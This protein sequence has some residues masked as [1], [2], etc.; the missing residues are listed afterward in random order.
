MRKR[1]FISVLNI[2][3]FGQAEDIQNILKSIK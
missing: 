2:N 3:S 1:L